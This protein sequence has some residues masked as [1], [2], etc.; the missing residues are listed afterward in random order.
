MEKV[1]SKFVI[2][3]ITTLPGNRLKQTNKDIG[4]FAD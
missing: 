1:E 4:P 2:L 3:Y